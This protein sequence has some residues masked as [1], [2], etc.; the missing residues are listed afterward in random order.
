M[1]P[2]SILREQ[3]G[4]E[5]AHRDHS[6]RIPIWSQDDEVTDVAYEHHARSVAHTARR[7]RPSSGSL[8]DLRTASFGPMPS[9]S[10]RVRVA[11]SDDL[12]GVV[13]DC[14]R[15]DVGAPQCL[16]HFA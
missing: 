14:C 8:S 10:A 16:R 1:R 9:A 6:G 7:G 13:A 11:L 15:R 3:D 5:V 12:A 2:R 4:E